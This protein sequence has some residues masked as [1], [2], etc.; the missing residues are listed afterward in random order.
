MLY[1]FRDPNAKEVD[2]TLK[3][4]LFVFC[5]P[6]IVQAQIPDKFLTTHI[7]QWWYAN[8]LPWKDFGDKKSG[9]DTLF[10]QD[11][12][13][14]NIFVGRWGRSLEVTH[15]YFKF[16]SLEGDTVHLEIVKSDRSDKH[17][18]ENYKIP[19]HTEETQ[20]Y[21]EIKSFP[22]RY[23]RLRLILK[24][25]KYAVI[26]YKLTVVTQHLIYPRRR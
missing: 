8:G 7:P 19:L 26:V 1:N 15:L 20:K 17:D 22:F 3:I 21:L 18:F 23:D 25:K 13:T 14:L 10:S 5:F 6:C 16:H 12:D 9:Q 2:M 11:A 24:N 4:I